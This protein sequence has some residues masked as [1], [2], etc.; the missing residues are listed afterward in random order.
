MRDHRDPVDDARSRGPKMP[1]RRGS[2]VV[3]VPEEGGFRRSQHEPSLL[4]AGNGPVI[5][6]RRVNEAEQRQQ[7]VRSE[8]SIVPG[9]IGHR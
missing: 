2:D 4:P 1:S 3:G 5:R 7:Q 6:A 9:D 8:A